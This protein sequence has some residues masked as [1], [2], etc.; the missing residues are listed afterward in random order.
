MGSNP[1]LSASGCGLANIVEI[2]GLAGLLTQLR[3]CLDAE[4][5]SGLRFPEIADMQPGREVHG[6]AAGIGNI[7]LASPYGFLKDQRAASPAGLN[8]AS[9]AVLAPTAPTDMECIG[10]VAALGVIR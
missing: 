1:T 3:T 10:P 9:V 4:E 2:N 7:S 6:R 5:L 8:L